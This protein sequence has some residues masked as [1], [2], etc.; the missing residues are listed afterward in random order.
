MKICEKF[1]G[2]CNFQTSNSRAMIQN[3][4]GCGKYC[5][6]FFAYSPLFDYNKNIFYFEEINGRE[7][8]EYCL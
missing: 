1:Y 8:T 7:R 2:Y 3:S 4:L 5:I 6:R